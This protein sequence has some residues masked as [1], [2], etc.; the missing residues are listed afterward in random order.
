M[1]IAD[2]IYMG[3]QALALEF[4]VAI[5]GGDTNVWDGPL[6]INVTLLGLERVGGSVLR[7]GARVGDIVLVTG[8]LGGSIAGRH[9]SFQ[10]RVAEAQ[11]LADR[12]GLTALTDISDGLASDLRDLCDESGIGIELNAAVIPIAHNVSGDDRLRAAMCDGEDFELAF[13]M[14]PGRA[15]RLLRDQP[16]KGLTVTAIGRVVND[17]GLFWIREDGRMPCSWG[18]YKHNS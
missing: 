10:P 8:S 2:G 11:V 18:G 4:D 6:V 17:P 14:A 12:Y 16:L 3:M 7:S 1:T 15:E 13:T 9:L 5:A